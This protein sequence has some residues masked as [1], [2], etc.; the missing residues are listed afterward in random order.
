[1]HIS[2]SLNDELIKALKLDGINDLKKY[3]PAYGG[4]SVGLDLYY[5][6][7]EPLHIDGPHIVSDNGEIKKCLVPTGLKIM[8]PKN[9]A[10]LI[11]DRGSISKTNLIRRAGVIDPGYTGEIF[12]NFLSVGGWVIKPYQKLP[13]QLVVIEANTLYKYVDQSSYQTLSEDSKRKDN[14]IGSTEKGE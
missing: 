14:K 5:A 6:G 4:E 10:G 1:M 9:Y 7:K 8:L 12:V 2:I 11:L 3:Q 13:V